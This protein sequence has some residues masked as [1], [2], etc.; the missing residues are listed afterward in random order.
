MPLPLTTPETGDRSI[1]YIQRSVE[2]KIDEG[3]P[4]TALNLSLTEVFP[5]AFP[6]SGE[7]SYELCGL[8]ALGSRNLCSACDEVV[9]RESIPAVYAITEN[10]GRRT[11]SVHRPA[12]NA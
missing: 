4:T 1:G 3:L 12:M 5:I 10:L 2:T 6:H 9:A 7:R 8:A 11:G